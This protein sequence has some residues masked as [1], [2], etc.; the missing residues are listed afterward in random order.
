MK[1]AKTTN[2]TKNPNPIILTNAIP[3]NWIFAS[4]TWGITTGG[5]DKRAD[6]TVTAVAVMKA[7]SGLGNTSALLG[8]GVG[9]WP[10][11]YSLE[12]VVGTGGAN[13]PGVG[14]VGLPNNC[15]ARAV[16]HFELQF[17]SHARGL[18]GTDNWDITSISVYARFVDVEKGQVFYSNTWPGQGL[19]LKGLGTVVVPFPTQG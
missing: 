13:G 3:P 7:G 18:E 5:D 16:D 15:P 8:D 2:G 10:N 9:D 17:K 1:D 19:R 11:N 12:F 4:V 14:G 6:S